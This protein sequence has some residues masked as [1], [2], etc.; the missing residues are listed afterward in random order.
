M[1]CVRDGQALVV[2]PA[3]QPQILGLDYVCT[4]L[5]NHIYIVLDATIRYNREN[6]YVNSMQVLNAMHL[7]I[8]INYVLPTSFD[9]PHVPHR[10]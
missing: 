10:S 6:R 9:N 2:F 3:V 7:Y 5:H 1:Y 8:T 4:F